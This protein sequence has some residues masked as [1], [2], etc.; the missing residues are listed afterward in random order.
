MALHG[1]CTIFDQHHRSNSVDL[2][3][4]ENYPGFKVSEISIID[5][6]YPI[7]PKSV[8]DVDAVKWLRRSFGPNS[9][10]SPRDLTSIRII[11][12]DLDDLQ[13]PWTLKIKEC[14]KDLILDHF[15]I[16]QAYAYSF[17][18]DRDLIRL[19]TTQALQPMRHSFSFSSYRSLRLSWTY[20][21]STD[22]TSALCVGYYNQCQ[23]M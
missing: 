18:T 12:V 10:T 14:N 16:K 4:K 19:P 22:S 6:D 11:W 20:D 8:L 13:R 5:Q 1:L 9:T 15:D 21:F 3:F 2:K 7:K 17:T 23:E